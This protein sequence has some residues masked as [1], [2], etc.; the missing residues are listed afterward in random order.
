M[1]YCEQYCNF[2]EA[3]LTMELKGVLNRGH[4]NFLF[5]VCL[6]KNYVKVHQRKGENLKKLEQ[7]ERGESICIAKTEGDNCQH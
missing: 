3:D 6:K 1:C 7:L 2:L 5:S 4:L